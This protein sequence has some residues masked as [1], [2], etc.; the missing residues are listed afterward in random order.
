[1]VNIRKKN[2]NYVDTLYYAVLGFSHRI[3]H[4]IQIIS[5][6]SLPSYSSS[7]NIPSLPPSLHRPLLKSYV[8][9]KMDTQ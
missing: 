8:E 9:K 6:T 4:N 7:L 2:C 1:M 5:F 3:L